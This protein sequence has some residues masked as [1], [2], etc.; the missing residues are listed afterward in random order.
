MITIRVAPTSANLGPGFDC[1][2]VT[3]DLGDV[4]METSFEEGGKGIIVIPQGWGQ[5]TLPR[6][7]SNLVARAFA[8]FASMNSLPLPAG[9]NIHTS[10]G[11]PIGSGLGSSAA[12][13]VSGLLAAREYYNTSCSMEEIANMAFALE[14]HA[15]NTT[16][17]LLGGLVVLTVQ[18][19]TVV[20]RRYTAAR[21]PVVLVRPEFNL[22]TRAARQALPKQVPFKN[23]V[24]SVGNTAL[25]VDALQTGDMDLLGKVNRDTLHQPYRLPLIPGAAQAAQAGLDAG[26][27]AVVLS[28]AGPSLLTFAPHKQEE[29]AIAMQEGFAKAGLQSQAFFG[30]TADKPAQVLVT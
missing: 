21:L 15:D 19:E 1:L 17:A 28:G 6:D 12:A 29:V 23:A 27:A 7:R 2:A 18:D 22:S 4:C 26:A 9:L 11:I 10:N 20:Y 5:E 30:W 16:A 25:L 13:I 14:G 3:L 8:H 24:S